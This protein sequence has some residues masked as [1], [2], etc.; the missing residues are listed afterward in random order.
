VQQVVIHGPDDVRI[1]EIPEPE[2][3]PDDVVVRMRACGICGSDLGY[4]RQGGLPIGVD[5]PMPLGHEMSGVVE[6]LGRDVRNL[7]IGQRVAISPMFAG[8]GNGGAEGG[9]TRRL[10]VRGAGQGG[11]LHPIPDSLPLDLASLAEPLG[12]G[13]RSVDRAQVAPRDKVVVVGAGPIGLSA[14]ATLRSRGVEDVIALD[15]SPRRRALAK[16]LGAREVLDASAPDVW[17]SLHGLHGSTSQYG[18]RSAGSDVYIEASGAPSV[19]PKLLES[20][21]RGSRISVVA[22][23]HETTPVAFLNVMMKELTIL[24]SIEYPPDWNDMLNLLE[25]WELS[26]MI[27][28]RF[29]LERFHDALA[30]ARDQRDCGK[31]LL[32]MDGAP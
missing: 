21:K 30:V 16:Q 3:G 32:E 14:I 11:R 2:P 6:E 7:K 29:P 10:L 20:A 9:L 8:I 12:V 22:I 25:R 27:T 5:G 17:E 24:G 28:H 18:I 31:V 4:I 13:M 26:P 1:D 19:L 15:L 23:H